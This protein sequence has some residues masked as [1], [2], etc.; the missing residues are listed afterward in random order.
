MSLKPNVNSL[1]F[2]LQDYHFLPTQQIKLHPLCP[3][4]KQTS[5]LIFQFR[6]ALPTL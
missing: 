5:L 3:A 2:Y 6:M 4:L 1:D